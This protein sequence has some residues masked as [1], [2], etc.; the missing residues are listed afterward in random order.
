MF[1]PLWKLSSM[2][3]IILCTF[4]RISFLVAL[5]IVKKPAKTDRVDGKLQSRA[6]CLGESWYL[7]TGLM[8]FLIRAPIHWVWGHGDSGACKRHTKTVAA[9]PHTCMCNSSWYFKVHISNYTAGYHL[10]TLRES[11]ILMSLP[12]IPSKRHQQWTCTTPTAF[13]SEI[14]VITPYTECKSS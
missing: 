14:Q 3:G 5:A 11:P 9:T 10:N 1:L 6:V 7:G 8:V 4:P 12:Q 13:C 2:G